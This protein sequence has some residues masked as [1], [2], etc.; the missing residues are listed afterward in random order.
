MVKVKQSRLGR[1][2]WFLGVQTS[3]Y[4]V[5]VSSR[6]RAFC[7][8]GLGT[9]VFGNVTLVSWWVQVTLTCGMSVFESLVAPGKTERLMGLPSSSVM[10]PQLICFFPR[11][12]SRLYPN[13]ASSRCSPST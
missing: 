4:R 11:F 3:V 2:I 12:W 7:C 5:M 1:G 10:R 6:S 8:W 13:A 9:V